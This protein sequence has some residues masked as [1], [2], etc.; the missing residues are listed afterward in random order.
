MNFISKLFNWYFTKNSLPYWVIFLLD[1]AI[2]M[3][4][5]LMAYW[6]FN[7]TG[8]LLANFWQ[9]VNS[10]LCFVLLSI[11]GFRLFNTYSGIM[12]FSSFVDLMRVIYSN[13]LSLC[14][15]L[16]TERV[17][18]ILPDE[19]FA[20]I[21]TTSIVLMFIL[22]TLLMWVARVVAKT[23]FEVT[24]SD[25]RAIRVLIYGALTGGVG[26]A[27]NIRSQRPR[28]YILKGFISH[29]ENLRHVTLMGE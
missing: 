16:M 28:K 27:K 23:I 25:N 8:M 3:A 26:L 24:T 2:V 18:D 15:A 1:C 7:K 12:R 19:W 20:D 17:I 9:V 10:L 6:M 13:L 29:A 14:L 22:S 21:N 5:G 11:I 4:S